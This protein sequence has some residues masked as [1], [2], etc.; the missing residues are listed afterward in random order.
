MVLM[1]IIGKGRN[2]KVYRANDIKSNK[3]YALK[4]Y[5]NENE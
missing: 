1:E 4:V 3:V 5:K 2:S